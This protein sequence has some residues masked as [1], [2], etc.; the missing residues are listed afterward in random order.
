M[1]AGLCS[2]GHDDCVSLPRVAYCMECGD[3]V[4]LTSEGSCRQGH[5][6]G[7]MHHHP[8]ADTDKW[9]LPAKRVLRGRR[10]GRTGLQRLASVD[11]H[12][13]PHRRTSL[14]GGHPRTHTE[15]K[16][17]ALG[18]GKR[19]TGGRP[20]RTPRVPL[21]HSRSGMVRAPERE[22]GAPHPATEDHSGSTRVDDAEAS[23]TPASR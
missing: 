4:P 22:A 13:L 15:E 11:L 9:P 19:A 20:F 7:L 2:E 21:S 12:V 6:R 23:P 8:P 5:R 18:D 3:I 1:E 17:W 10:A 14:R 16:R